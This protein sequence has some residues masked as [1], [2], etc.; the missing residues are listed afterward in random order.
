MTVITMSGLIGSG[1]DTAAQYLVDHH[2]F[3]R[4]SF[5]GSLKDAVA[6]VFGWPRD[7]LEGL[8]DHSRAWREQVDPWW[9]QRL[10][11]PHLT[12]RW[13]LQYWGT[14][15]L[16]NH[17]HDDIWIASVEYRMIN[18]AG[19]A[20]ISDSRFP[21]ELDLVRRHGGLSV[22]VQRGP[23]PEWYQTA[24]E[25][26]RGDLVCQ[27]IMHKTVHISEWAWAG[28]DFDLVVDNN[29]SL[30]QLYQQL[31]NLVLRLA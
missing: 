26:A 12:P 2:G 24:V 5:A 31:D 11:I 15:V 29:G 19:N 1:K 28:Y 22:L 25:A 27:E 21:N 7:M 10:S 14:D 4:L 20:V 8:T 9:S 30:Q 3:D 18:Q 17:F 13:V 16:R 6:S 23:W